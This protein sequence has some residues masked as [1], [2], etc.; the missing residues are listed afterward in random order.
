MSIY[1]TK[2]H[3]WAKTEQDFVLV[4][5]TEYAASQLGDIV[6]IK[7]PD[8]ETYS[9]NQTLAEIESVKAA[10]DI[11]SPVSGQVLEVNSKLTD[12]PE[13]INKSPQE[14]GWIAKIKMSNPQELEK[15]MDQD[16][17]DKYIQTL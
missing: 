13:I 5:I 4:G 7:L 15:L 1:Y 14:D 2:N 10:S 8:K 12:S 9:Q 11:D 6:F 16:S 3:E 17:Y